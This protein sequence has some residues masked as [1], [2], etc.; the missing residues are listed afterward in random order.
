MTKL[1]DYLRVSEAAEYL[2]VCP[3]TLRNWERA[4]KIVAHRH[5]MNDYRL[6]KREELDAL[7]KQVQEPRRSKKK[8]K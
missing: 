7:L 8:P 5:P 2:G 6:F 1:S 4:G 3:N